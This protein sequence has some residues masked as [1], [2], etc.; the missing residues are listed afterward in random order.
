[1]QY[2]AQPPGS[3]A[4]R[5]SSP[6]GANPYGSF[7]SAPQPAY[8]DAAPSRSVPPAYGETYGNGQQPDGSWRPAANVGYLPANGYSTGSHNGNGHNG[9]GPGYPARDQHDV[10]GGYGAFDYQNLSYQDV[11]YQQA[12]PAADGYAQRPERAGQ[13]DER[14]YGVPDLAY[15]QDGY[16]SYPGYGSRG[17]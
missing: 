13:F 3:E 9:N 10:Q 1:M 12:Q 16:Q 8:Q 17:R 15:G 11:D 5:P 7:V 2:P 4:L 14:S 6:P